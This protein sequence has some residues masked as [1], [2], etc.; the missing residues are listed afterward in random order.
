MND[1]LKAALKAYLTDHNQNVEEVTEVELYSSSDCCNAGDPSLD[2][3]YKIPGQRWR[4]SHELTSYEVEDLLE[5]LVE[6]VVEP[7][8]VG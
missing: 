8:D 6:Y 1:K 5:F 7:S 4:S 3:N 2:I